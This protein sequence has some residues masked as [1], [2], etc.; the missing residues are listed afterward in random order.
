MKTK[1]HFFLIRVHFDAPVIR[2][3]ALHHVRQNLNGQNY[4]PEWDGEKGPEEFWIKSVKSWKPER[5]I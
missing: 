2:K 1:N 3:H 5:T 4:Y